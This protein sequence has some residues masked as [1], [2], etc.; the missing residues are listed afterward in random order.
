MDG[1]HGFD[2]RRFEQQ[3]ADIHEDIEVNAWGYRHPT[4]VGMQRLV[5]E[6]ARR[7]QSMARLEHALTQL[8]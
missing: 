8:R 4:W 1:R 3:L 2:Q 5:H 6:A 7:S